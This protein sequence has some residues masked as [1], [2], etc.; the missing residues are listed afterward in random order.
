MMRNYTA[1]MIDNLDHAFSSL[2]YYPRN[3]L[4][5][6]KKNSM[7][8]NS[9]KFKFMAPGVNNI[10]PLSLYVKAKIFHVPVK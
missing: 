1:A 6:F 8:A 4:K 3:A 7:K 10:A 9:G 2:K 5:Q